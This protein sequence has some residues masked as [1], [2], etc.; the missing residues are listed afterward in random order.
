MTT[1]VRCRFLG[2]VEQTL[3]ADVFIRRVEATAHLWYKL[4]SADFETRF[5]GIA[6]GLES[7]RDRRQS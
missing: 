3:R 6:S 7:G 4:Q 2:S 1:D 5:S